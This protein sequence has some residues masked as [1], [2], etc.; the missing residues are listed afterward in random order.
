[1][2]D[3]RYAMSLRLTASLQDVPVYLPLQCL[4]DAVP[5]VFHTLIYA[6]GNTYLQVK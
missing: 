4:L 5:N 6:Y 3:N 1:M 2:P